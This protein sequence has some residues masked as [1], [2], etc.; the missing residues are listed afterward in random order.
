MAATKTCRRPVIGAAL[1]AMALMPTDGFAVSEPLA[2]RLTGDA[3][4]ATFAG[5]IF[6]GAYQDGTGWREAYLVDGRVDYE[7]DFRAA[8]G[9]WFVRDDLL[10]TFY[11]NDLTGG[12]FV[13]MRRSA[14][15]FDFYAVD[16]SDD[17][18]VAGW[19]AVRG[20]FGWTAQGNRSDQAPTCADGLLS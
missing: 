16:L 9:D 14:N 15:C 3:L 13:V 4:T 8:A 20:G 17:A 18:P 10:C 12:C 7:D 11:D 5:R 2:G 19:D 1:L 6:R